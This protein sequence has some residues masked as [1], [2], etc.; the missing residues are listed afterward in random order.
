MRCNHNL[1]NPNVLF[2]NKKTCLHILISVYLMFVSVIVVLCITIVLFC[3]DYIIYLQFN[4]LV[5]D[6]GMVS[7]ALIACEW[8]S[9]PL[10]VSIIITIGCYQSACEHCSAMWFHFISKRTPLLSTAN[11]QL[12]S[13]QIN[14]NIY[15]SFEYNKHLVL[16]REF[17]SGARC[18]LWL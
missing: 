8:I 1:N 14:H 15:F 17:A 13:L 12:F 11:R 6:G 5:S 10:Y 2:S 3:W 16:K 7:F 9:A 18:A 4:K